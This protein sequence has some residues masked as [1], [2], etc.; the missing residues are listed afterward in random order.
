MGLNYLLLAKKQPVPEF[1]PII[2]SSYL[3]R[4]SGLDI[5]GA[6]SS[7]DRF[8]SRL[9]CDELSRVEA[10]PTGIFFSYLSLPHKRILLKS[11]EL[12]KYPTWTR[13]KSYANMI[14][15]NKLVLKIN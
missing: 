8:N 13:H 9:A 4:T 10:A 1:L 5:V 6:A 11:I 14:D 7:R 3:V 15:F 2:V 12:L